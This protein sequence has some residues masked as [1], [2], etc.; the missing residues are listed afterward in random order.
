MWRWMRFKTWPAQRRHPLPARSGSNDQQPCHD[1]KPHVQ[2]REDLGHFLFRSS[3]LKRKRSQR[4]S[5]GMLRC[6]PQCHLWNSRTD[7]LG[8]CEPHWR[9][10]GGKADCWIGERSRNQ[11]CVTGV[12]S[13]ESTPQREEQSTGG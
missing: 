9:G 8:R 10:S 11:L 12:P 6:E 4:R 3:D 1:I 5:Y 13:C 7:I 2:L